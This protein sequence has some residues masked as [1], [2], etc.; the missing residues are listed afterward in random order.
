MEKLAHYGILV[1][2][3]GHAKTVGSIAAAK[4]LPSVAKWRGGAVLQ[5]GIWFLTGGR[6]RAL[7]VE[8]FTLVRS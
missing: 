5:L 8:C 3:I 1:N 2:G 7:F 4:G 6:G